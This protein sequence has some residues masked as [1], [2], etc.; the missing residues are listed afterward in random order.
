MYHAGS[1]HATPAT[2][3]SAPPLFTLIRF[4]L[5]SRQVTLRLKVLRLPINAAAL[6]ISRASTCLQQ[7]LLSVGHHCTTNTHHREQE[8]EKHFSGERV[9]NTPRCVCPHT[10]G[11]GPD[12][13]DY[14]TVP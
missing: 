5:A 14:N 13:T 8:T 1:G 2:P 11:E 6:K 3:V 9:G 12:H 7:Q 10:S 4:K